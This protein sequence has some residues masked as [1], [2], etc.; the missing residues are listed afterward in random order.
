MISFRNLFSKTLSAIRGHWFQAICVFFVYNLMLGL[1]FFSGLGILLILIISGPLMIGICVYSLKI[2][3]DNFPKAEDLIFG[4]K[5]NLGNGI[6]AYF[7]IIPIILVC[8]FLLMLLLFAINFFIYLQI[9]SV[10]YSQSYEA[11]TV[12]MEWK[13]LL[14]PFQLFFEFGFLNSI[15]IILFIIISFCFSILFPFFIVS[16]PFSMTFYIMADDTSIDA[17]DAIQESWSMMKGFKRSYLWLNFILLLL[18]IPVSI[19]TLCIGLLW[20]IPFSS[21]ITGVFYEEIKSIRGNNIQR[22]N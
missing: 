4:F 9:L 22:I 5:F 19:F 2:I 14:S 16:I 1:V 17:W 7:I 15:L 6:L 18:L 8:G 10:Y 21:I 11:F 12:S 20:F 13:A 3:R